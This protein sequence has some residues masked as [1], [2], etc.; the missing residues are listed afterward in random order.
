[1]IDQSI[2]DHTERENIRTSVGQRLGI[3]DLGHAADTPDSRFIDK[4]FGRLEKRYAE[5][6]AVKLDIFEHLAV[7]IL[8][9]MQRHEL[10]GQHN[11]RERKDRQLRNAADFF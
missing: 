9:N 7:A 2:A 3:A 8:K 5:K 10:V 11:E 1:M 6:I 4:R